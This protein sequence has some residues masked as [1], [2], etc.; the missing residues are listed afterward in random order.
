MALKVAVGAIKPSRL[1]E[2][3]AVRGRGGRSTNIT[4]DSGPV[5]PGNRVEG[6]TLKTGEVRKHQNPG[7]PI[8]LLEH[9]KSWT[10]DDG[11]GVDES[12]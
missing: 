1:R 7:V 6:K 3:E 5:K 11:G 9:G 12:S 10:R 8:P 4:D 2:P